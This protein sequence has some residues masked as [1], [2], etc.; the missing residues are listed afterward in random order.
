M[1]AT[2]A[3]NA[4]NAIE[5]V[6]A[7][8]TPA[9]ASTVRRSDT[10]AK[11]ATAVTKAVAE[12]KNPSK[13]SV[14]PYYNSKYADLATVRDAVLPVLARHDLAVLQLPCELDNAAALTTLLTHTSGEWVETTIKLRPVRNDPQGVG[15]AL[16]YA[17]RYA[18]Q[19]IAGVAAE[20]DDDGNAA[21]RRGKDGAEANGRTPRSA[22]PALA[23]A[24]SQRLAGCRTQ[25]E[26]KA[27]CDEIKSAVAARR[28]TNGDRE[29]LVAVAREA[30]A[31]FPETP[32]ANGASHAV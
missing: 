14:N 5:S 7:T 23:G 1:N 22:A 20:D 21:G 29:T 24:Y 9:F 32:A 31:R 19:S 25:A 13:D 15:S 2:N 8:G 30:A 27:L 6:P 11:M 3:T 17:R 12:L 4:T 26:Y 10:I 28:L 16:T 18:L